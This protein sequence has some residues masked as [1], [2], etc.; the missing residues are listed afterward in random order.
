MYKT[1]E[2]WV[3]FVVGM[4]GAVASVY[5][6]TRLLQLDGSGW[7]HK[8]LGPRLAYCQNHHSAVLAYDTTK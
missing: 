6:V 3:G 2:F 7:E 8:T 4:L 5:L 1:A